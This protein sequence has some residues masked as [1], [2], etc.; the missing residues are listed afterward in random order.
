M[1]QP[2]PPV[3][4]AQ[5]TC[6]VS[7]IN[8]DPGSPRPPFDAT[9]TNRTQYVVPGCKSLASA[10]HFFFPLD[11]AATEVDDASVQPCSIFFHCNSYFV[12]DAMGL[13]STTIDVCI[14]AMGKIFTVEENTKIKNQTRIKRLKGKEKAEKLIETL[15]YTLATSR[16]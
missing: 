11:P 5:P 13:K 2:P 16:L 15:L 14:S 12:I 10:W 4:G 8:S 1:I 6:S 9:Q 3:L 7:I